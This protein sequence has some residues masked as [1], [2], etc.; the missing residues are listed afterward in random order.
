MRIF[1]TNR[2][3][4]Q[5]TLC[6]L[7]I[8]IHLF[9]IGYTFLLS[10]QGQASITYGKQQLILHK[11]DII[12]FYPEESFSLHGSPDSYLLLITLDPLH[13]NHCFSPLQ[14]FICFYSNDSDQTTYKNLRYYLINMA[15]AHYTDSKNNDNY[16][17]AQVFQ[18]LHYLKTRPG[19]KTE[20]EIM[21]PSAPKQHAKIKKINSFIDE[22]YSKQ[23]TLQE[24]ANYMA[25][26][27]QY[28]ASFI[29]KY[30]QMTFYE[31]LNSIRL[32]ATVLLLKYSN[33]SL[34]KI[35]IDGGFPNTTTFLKQFTNKHAIK[36]LDFRKAFLKRKERADIPSDCQINNLPLIK[37]LLS[38]QAVLSN[39][40]LAI[41]DSHIKEM[42]CCNAR[43]HKPFSPSWKKLIN[44]GDASNFEN[45]GFRQHLSLV[46]L[47]IGFEYGRIQNVFSLI[48]NCIVTGYIENDMTNIFRIIDYLSSLHIKPLF[49]IG[50]KHAHIYMNDLIGNSQKYLPKMNYFED[51]LKPLLPIF[52]KSCI[53]HYGFHAVSEWQFEFWQEYNNNMTIVESPKS[54]LNKFKYVY[55]TIKE[56]VPKAYVGGPGFNTYMNPDHL[57]NT[58]NAMDRALVKPD[59]ISIYVYPYNDEITAASMW[60]TGQVSLASNQDIYKNRIEQC[61]DII[62]Q[63]WTQPPDLYVTEYGTHIISNNY[64]NDGLYPASLIIR[65][66]L[67][68]DS[69]AK[70]MSY[71][72]LSDF[73]LDFKYSPYILFGG[74]G[75]ISKDGIK[76]P[77]FFA[78]Q[79]LNLLG[80]RIISKGEHYI[81]TSSS[82]YNYQ[83]LVYYYGYFNEDYC[84]HQEDYESLKYPGSP[85]VLLKPL[86]LSISL[87]N[88][89]E[90]I[91]HINQWTLS[92][93]LGN[94][95][96]EWKKLGTK[97]DLSNAEIAYLKSKSTPN[98]N[99]EVR[100]VKKKLTLNTELTMHEAVLYQVNHLQQIEE[101]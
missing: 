46:Q 2:E 95:L 83:I 25:F 73:S 99:V 35:A 29:K 22:N 69:R 51:I 15:V 44:L 91:Y 52:L 48:D 63:T 100:K 67:D 37:G 1:T 8:P 34:N 26:T 101:A 71:W 97:A 4:F 59:F 81:I 60:S 78:Y 87:E 5:I 20:S 85:F 92:D 36:P 50:S 38:D 39:T 76:K 27:P 65:E 17:M 89:E 70:A 56:L 3:I 7:S 16:L 72:L 64:L 43:K 40:A 98:L 45:P 11:Q 10:L 41:I 55:T 96:H 80:N 9:N 30:F 84:M 61:H 74:N 68:N 33:E 53:N 57:S 18:L 32:K 58:L 77:G 19:V 49:D 75:I 62:R 14:R 6:K 79:F 82:K 47:E 90:G 31:Y 54:Y 88:L 93:T 86:S 94:L 12:L 23:I 66:S 28:L 21:N 42:V 24:L 13:F